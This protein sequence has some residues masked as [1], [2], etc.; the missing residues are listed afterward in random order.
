MSQPRVSGSRHW[1]DDIG[2]YIR[3][4][5]KSP[6]IRSLAGEQC[7]E[8]PRIASYSQ[9]AMHADTSSSHGAAGR[10]LAACGQIVGARL[11]IR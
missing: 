9:S 7:D 8:P 6:S 2:Q 5:P 1:D 4:P 10:I 11:R 3:R